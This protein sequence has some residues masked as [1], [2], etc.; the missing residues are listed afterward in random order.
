MTDVKETK[1]VLVAAIKL[2][3]TGSELAK[4]GIDLSDAVALG[5]K[6]ISDEEFRIALVEGVKGADK[7]I[8]EIK[9]MDVLEAGQLLKAAADEL[10]K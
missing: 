5:S 2:I 1:E 4:D 3:K 6:F 8:A 10:A 9:D 7:I